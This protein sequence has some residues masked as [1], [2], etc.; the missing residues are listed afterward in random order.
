MH[1]HSPVLF[2]GREGHSALVSFHRGSELKQIKMLVLASRYK[3]E[4]STHACKQ[5]GGVFR[6]WEWVYLPAQLNKSPSEMAVGAQNKCTDTSFDPV[7][8]S[9]LHL[10]YFRSALML[11]CWIIQPFPFRDNQYMDISC[12]IWNTRTHCM[13][14]EKRHGVSDLYQMRAFLQGKA[15]GPRVFLGHSASFQLT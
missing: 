4:T 9:V 14:N 1:W 13:L 7:A 5:F 10:T 3:L 6:I 8:T 12:L 11:F 2:W 15:F